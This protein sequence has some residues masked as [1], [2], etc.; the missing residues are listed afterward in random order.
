MSHKDAILFPI[1]ASCILFGLYLLF[2]FLGKDYVN[3]LLSLY[4][5]VLGIYAFAATF[6]PVIAA[7]SPQWSKSKIFGFTIPNLPFMASIWREGMIMCMKYVVTLSVGP[8]AVNFS[9]L[10]I[11]VYGIS[12]VLNVLYV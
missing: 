11:V 3:Y 4:F 1:I 10:D 6:E 12:A 2:K 8:V 9:S 7:V 5:L